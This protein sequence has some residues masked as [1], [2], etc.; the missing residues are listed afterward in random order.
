MPSTLSL[1]TLI[2]SFSKGLFLIQK[3][4]SSADSLNKSMMDALLG[5]LT[6]VGY[7]MEVR[8][9]ITLMLRKSFLF[10]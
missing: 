2:I 7:G 4:D 1:N 10:N 8:G 5:P 9:L 3:K 6:E